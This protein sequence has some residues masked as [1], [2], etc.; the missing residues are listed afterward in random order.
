MS[1]G[2]AFDVLEKAI[3]Y[4]W[5]RVNPQAGQCSNKGF[6]YCDTLDVNLLLR[7]VDSIIHRVSKTDHYDFLA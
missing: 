5:T 2:K 7:V 3:F 4:I 1:L 6:D